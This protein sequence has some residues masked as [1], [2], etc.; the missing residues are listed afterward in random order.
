MTG[1]NDI[2]F[3]CFRFAQFVYLNLQKRSTYAS[4]VKIFS[5]GPA[6]M[7][8]LNGHPLAQRAETQRTSLKSRSR[9]LFEVQYKSYLMWPL[10]C[11][12]WLLVLFSE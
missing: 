9:A 11:T 12:L 3:S 4:N 7:N 8:G 2:I 10:Y 1:V 5:A 6:L